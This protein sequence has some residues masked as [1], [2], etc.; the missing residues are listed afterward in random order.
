M[1]TFRDI[2]M[3]YD[4]Q[5]SGAIDAALLQEFI[6]ELPMEIGFNALAEEEEIDPRELQLVELPDGSFRGCYLNGSRGSHGT[7]RTPSRTP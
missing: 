5:A 2:W 7:P 4:P 3:Q 1:E 6:G